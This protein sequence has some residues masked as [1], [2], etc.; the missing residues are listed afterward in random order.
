MPKIP[1]IGINNIKKNSYNLFEEELDDSDAD[2][3]EEVLSNMSSLKE[4]KTKK[5]IPELIVNEYYDDFT[6]NN[7]LEEDDQ[8]T[9]DNN[10]KLSSN[11]T[12]KKI[13]LKGRKISRRK[14]KIS[15]VSIRNKKE[16]SN[17]SYNQKKTS[18]PRTFLKFKNKKK[19][20]DYRLK[21]NLEHISTKKKLEK[22]QVISNDQV[23]DYV[24]NLSRN[25]LCNFI[26]KLNE[27]KLKSIW[28]QI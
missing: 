26:S 27:C 11:L 15:E 3:Y 16:S 23:W 7:F 6:K 28:K 12:K 5:K 21:T 1:N 18:E 24:D 4:S 10:S 13:N 2:L 20:N 19:I 9:K 8:N 14:R 25:S 22:V 17:F